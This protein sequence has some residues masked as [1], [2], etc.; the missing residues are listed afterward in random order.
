MG[1]TGEDAILFTPVTSPIHYHPIPKKMDLDFFESIAKR[2]K[3]IPFADYH[4]CSLQN[5]IIRPNIDK[6]CA[7][8]GITSQTVRNRVLDD[9]WVFLNSWFEE[10]DDDDEDDEEEEDYLIPNKQTFL[11]DG[12]VEY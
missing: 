9:T 2:L 3:N 1:A 6:I 5:N 4:S 12:A 10:K 8:C 11:L 7:D